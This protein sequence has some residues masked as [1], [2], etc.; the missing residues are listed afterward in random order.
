[1]GKVAQAVDDRD[2]RVL[3]QLFH[4]FMLKRARDDAV[5]PPVQVARDV[6]ERRPVADRAG[7]RSASRRPAAGMPG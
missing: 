4:F 1:M 6:L 5:G 2:G 7:P 3:R